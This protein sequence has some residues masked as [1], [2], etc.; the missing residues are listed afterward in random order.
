MIA[1]LN[2]LI[3]TNAPVK[4]QIDNQ[5]SFDILRIK[6]TKVLC[7]DYGVYSKYCNHYSLPNEFIVYNE[8]GLNGKEIQIKPAAMWEET[9]NG[10]KKVADFYYTFKCHKGDKEPI[11]IQNI[12]PTPGYDVN[13]MYKVILFV[14]LLSLVVYCSC[15]CN[16]DDDYYYSR[17][18][19]GND[20][21]IGYLLGSNTNSSYSNRTYC[22]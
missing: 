15:C 14:V 5:C 22:E 21:W 3:L 10:K 4:H 6:H 11:V 2:L 17:N 7:N 9:E 8:K 19:S 12:V 1:L 18:N 13:P 16:S 20:F